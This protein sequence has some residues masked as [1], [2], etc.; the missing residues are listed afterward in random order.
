MKTLNLT[1]EE[2]ATLGAV[3]WS[4]RFT[5]A[6][7]AGQHE[8]VPKWRAQTAQAAPEGLRE[9]VA[10]TFGDI[11]EDIPMQAPASKDPEFAKHVRIVDSI[12]GKLCGEPMRLG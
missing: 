7:L 10:E 5:M 1:P 8:L 12:L 4:L 11:D 3:L 6:R 9:A 2:V